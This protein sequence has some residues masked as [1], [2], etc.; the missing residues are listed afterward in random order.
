MGC[1]I[2]FHATHNDIRIGS[3]P[4]QPAIFSQQMPGLRRTVPLRITDAFNE[5]VNLLSMTKLCYYYLTL[6]IV[7]ENVDFKTYMSIWFNGKPKRMV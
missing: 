2:L 1:L 5:L 6:E 7:H 4:T 3:P